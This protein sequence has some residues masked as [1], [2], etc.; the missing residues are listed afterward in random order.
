MPI[1]KRFW[2]N[3][4]GLTPILVIFIILIA[5]AV[6]YFV[7]SRGVITPTVTTPYDKVF[8][9]KPQPVAVNPVKSDASES[10]L[11]SEEGGT[12]TLKDQHELT[13]T[14]PK[15]ALLSPEEISLQSLKTIDGLPEGSRFITGA[16]LAPDGLGFVKS[17][18]LSIKLPPGIPTEN[19]AAFAYE[20]GGQNFYFQ[21][22]SID[23]DTFEI[24]INGFSG[25]G[26]IDI[27]ALIPIINP[28]TPEQT[29]KQLL[30]DVLK[31]AGGKMLNEIKKGKE[32]QFD[33]KLL[34]EA[35]GILNA[36]YQ[37]GVKPD[38]KTAE[39]D[40][41]KVDEAIGHMLVWRAQVNVFGLDQHFQK[42]FEESLNSAAKGVKHGVHQS[43]QRCINQK[44]PRQVSA[45]LRWLK[46]SQVL[47]LA[48]RAGLSEEEIQKKAKNCV[49]FEIKMDSIF[50]VPLVGNMKIPAQLKGTLELSGDF[51][52]FIGSG[53]VDEGPMW[54][55]TGGGGSCQTQ[56]NSYGFTINDTQFNI[57]LRKV[58]SPKINLFISFDGGGQEVGLDC[59]PIG[60][61]VAISIPAPWSADY[62][63]GFHEA[64]LVSKS[65]RKYFLQNWQYLGS[66]EIYAQKIYKKTIYGATEN[67]T[68][69]LKHTPRK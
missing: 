3:Q 36:W 15:G 2:L 31:R 52:H 7:F 38:L 6:G 40:D 63:E 60:P 11:I 57:N 21:P 18:T 17:S 39:K 59:R 47:G 46:L 22:Y 14:L 56:P 42:E 44:D 45:L 5:G 53:I 66:G 8:K 33:Q 67:T 28:G 4:K 68:F 32:G 41:A 26:I 10:A 58:S 24:P 61:G 48:G 9:S 13:L 62:F 35:R 37:N 51:T 12:L 1:R 43:S 65:E 69:T 25:G 54:Y 20:E 49:V 34:D 50:T 27:P 23:G 29:A 16:E 30:A 64:E 55:S 19:L